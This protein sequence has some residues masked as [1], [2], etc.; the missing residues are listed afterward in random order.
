LSLSC[1]GGLHL[2]PQWVRTSCHSK[3]NKNV[4]DAFLSKTTLIY[5][6]PTD[7]QRC[8][9]YFI[10]HETSFYISE[11]FYPWEKYIDT[12]LLRI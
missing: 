1:L 12:F 3:A 9:C 6:G 10:K 8:Y 11:I 5:K 2:F 7:N 4:M